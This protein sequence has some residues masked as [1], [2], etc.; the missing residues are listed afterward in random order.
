MTKKATSQ[1]VGLKDSSKDSPY[2]LQ[3]VG[4]KVLVEEEPIE[5]TA[6]ISSGLTPDVVEMIKAGSLLLPDQ[7]KYMVEKYPYVGTIL[8]IGS[9]CKKGLIAGERIHFAR[10]GVQRF[11]HEGKQFLVMDEQDV[12][13]FYRS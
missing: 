8:S 11:D 3:M 9:R 2:K 10:Q 7:G 6:D 1:R 5:L 13:G 12:H 4:T